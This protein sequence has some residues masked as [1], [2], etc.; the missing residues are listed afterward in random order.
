MREGGGDVSRLCCDAAVT[1]LGGGERGGTRARGGEMAVLGGGGG[2]GGGSSRRK[3]RE[4]REASS[5]ASDGYKRQRF[6]KSSAWE[7]GGRGGW[8]RGLQEGGA[9]EPH[10]PAPFSSALVPTEEGEKESGVEK[11]RWVSSKE[12]RKE[13]V[14]CIDNAHTTTKLFLYKRK[15]ENY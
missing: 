4:K 13:W 7:E 15:L 12:E 6:D 8:V 2:G 10:N 3:K 1:S 14:C 11:K 5:A 9:G